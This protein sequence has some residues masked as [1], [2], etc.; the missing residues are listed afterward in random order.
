M[1]VASEFQL[2]PEKKI[3]KVLEVTLELI[4]WDQVCVMEI[5]HT[6]VLGIPSDEDDFASVQEVGR[7]HLQG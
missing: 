3:R 6:T 5:R 4:I 7:Q 2:V 1:P